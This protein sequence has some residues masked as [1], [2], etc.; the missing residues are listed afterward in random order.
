MSVRPRRSRSDHRRGRR[1]I[2]FV[3]Q[4]EASDCGAA[5]LSM[6]LGLH[7]RHVPLEEVRKFTGSGRGGVSAGSILHAAEHYKLHCR[8]VRLEPEDLAA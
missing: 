4:L 8:G 5:C 7:G 3:Q 2:P 1:R 6:V